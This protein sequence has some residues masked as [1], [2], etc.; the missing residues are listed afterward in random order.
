MLRLA[1][2]AVI[3]ELLGERIESAGLTGIIVDERTHWRMPRE[4][5][6]NE[7]IK[8]IEEFLERR[9]RLY[10][11]QYFLAEILHEA[12]VEQNRAV[13]PAMQLIVDLRKSI[14]DYVFNLTRDHCAYYCNEAISAW[15]YSDS[16]RHDPSINQMDQLIHL[17]NESGTQSYYFLENDPLFYRAC[18]WYEEQTEC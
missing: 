11:V 5:N 3:Y 1:A 4:T 17:V 9:M 7:E 6:Q 10:D 13:L 2:K 8:M 16:C 14:D 18:D 15:L 12:A